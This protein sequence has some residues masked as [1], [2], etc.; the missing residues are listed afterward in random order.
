MATALR[1]ISPLFRVPE[2]GRDTR[3]FGSPDTRFSGSK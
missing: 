1:L 3:R 2:A